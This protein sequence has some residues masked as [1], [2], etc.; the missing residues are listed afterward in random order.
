MAKMTKRMMME[1]EKSHHRYE[2]R[3]ACRWATHGRVKLLKAWR[4]MGERVY[5]IRKF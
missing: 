1:A 2:H 4:V 3:E 5:G